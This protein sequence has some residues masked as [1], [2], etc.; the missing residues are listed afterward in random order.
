MNVC[1]GASWKYERGFLQE[2]EHPLGEGGY[3][4]ETTKA[5]RCSTRRAGS[6]GWT[7]SNRLV[8][9]EWLADILYLRD[10]ALKVK[11]FREHNFEDLLHIDT[12]RSA[13]KYQCGTHRLGE[14]SSLVGYFLLLFAGEIDEVVILGAHEDWNSGLVE[15][16]T[17]PIPFLNAVKG[18]LA[19]EVK[20]E[21]DGNR[22]V[23]NQGKHVDEL[24]LATQVPDAEGDLGVAD[25]D[26]LLHEIDAQGL[27]VVLVPAA[28]HILDHQACLADLGI[29]NH[30]DFDDDMA[31][32]VVR[33]ATTTAL[34]RVSLL[35]LGCL[36]VVVARA[37]AGAWRNARRWRSAVAGIGIHVYRGRCGFLAGG[38]GG[39]DALVERLGLPVGR[40]WQVLEAVVLGG[41]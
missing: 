26:C 7:K 5:I 15:A 10:C 30:A 31:S 33:F 21:Q 16:S 3:L 25:A 23:A 39:Y 41:G 1:V 17:L 27:D 37:G 38:A 18:A 14:S 11:G 6:D 12:V 19:S 24:A 22:I 20:H 34:V 40:L 4:L 8:E 29:T 32:A 2:N 35:G 9:K 13:T 36:A 28:L